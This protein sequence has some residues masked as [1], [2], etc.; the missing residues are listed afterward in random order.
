MYNNL[1]FFNILYVIYILKVVDF[2]MDPIY[3]ISTYL[4]TIKYLYTY[5]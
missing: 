4:S 5:K 2:Q 3:F 1:V